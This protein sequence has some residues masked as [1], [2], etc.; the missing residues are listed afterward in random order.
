VSIIKRLAP[1]FRV[2]ANKALD[3]A[4]DPRE[5]LEIKHAQKLA[6]DNK[7]AKGFNTADVAL[8]FGLLNAEVGEAFTA[9]RKKLP[10]LGE[11][12][13]DILIY[14]LSLAEMNGLDLDVEVEVARK[15]VKNSAR[16]YARD[17]HGIPVRLAEA[18]PAPDPA[19]SEPAG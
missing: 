16:I 8:E 12:L 17:A 7:I 5:V 2:K 4:E 9:W 6:W 19:E 15:I 13:A 18:V 10:D 1:L 14:A 3:R 11:E